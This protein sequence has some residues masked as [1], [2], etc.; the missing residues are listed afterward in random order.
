MTTTEDPALSSSA[1]SKTGVW[2]YFLLSLLAAGPF[3]AQ[4]AAAYVQWKNVS[5]FEGKAGMVATM[6]TPMLFFAVVCL[7]W[8]L[9]FVL[10]R[11]SA[12][13][14]LANAVLSVFAIQTIVFL[15]ELL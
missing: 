14:W 12:A 1:R 9:Y 3:A 15:L 6:M 4:L 8:G 5:N 13:L 11:W 2:L 10:R 7:L